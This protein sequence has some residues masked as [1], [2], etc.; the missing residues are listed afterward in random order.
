[1]GA[2]AVLGDHDWA[3]SGEA[4]AE[5]LQR[6]GV[7]VLIGES[8]VATH[9]AA[10]TR[11]TVPGLDDVASDRRSGWPA[12]SDR[13]SGPALALTHSPDIWAEMTPRP[14]LTLAGQTHGGQVAPFGSRRLR[15]PRHGRLYPC[16]WRAEGE[17]RLHA[18]SGVGASPPPVRLQGPPEIA[19]IDMTP[20]PLSD[21]APAA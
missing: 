18:T 5:S 14:A 7:R 9:P 3:W 19:V 17:A 10:R 4:V 8:A 2:Y 21:A 12:L 16:G 6:E 11:L 13:A 15:L 1:M 20:A